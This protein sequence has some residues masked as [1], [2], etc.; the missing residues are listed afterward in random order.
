MDRGLTRQLQQVAKLRSHSFKRP[1][2]WLKE[3][4]DFLLSTVPEGDVPEVW[5]RLRLDFCCE[6]PSFD[7]SMGRQSTAKP[8]ARDREERTVRPILGE[9]DADISPSRYRLATG[10]L[11]ELVAKP[12]RAKVNA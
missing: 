4:V 1:I 12:P 7:A 9:E 11:K 2:G 5:A 10:D 6:L 8:L 3:L